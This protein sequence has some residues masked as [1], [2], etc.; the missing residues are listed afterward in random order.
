ML[1]TTRQS[2]D[3]PPPDLAHPITDSA[4]DRV[5]QTAEHDAESDANGTPDLDAEPIE[6]GHTDVASR[7]LG[8]DRHAEEVETAEAAGQTGIVGAA[9]SMQAFLRETGIQ[10]CIDSGKAFGRADNVAKASAHAAIA[11]LYAHLVDVYRV[12]ADRLMGS[13]H[14]KAL[15]TDKGLPCTEATR[16]NPY[17]TVIRL[18]SPGI[19]RKRAS[20][21]ATALRLAKLREVRPEELEAFMRANGG[22]DGCA[23]R[24][25]D[26]EKDAREGSDGSDSGQPPD[27]EPQRG[28]LFV[29]GADAL[30]P[31]RHVVAIVV[32]DDGAQIVDATPSIGGEAIH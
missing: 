21:L 13:P 16:G 8:G 15:C 6:A 28:G 12:N 23:K 14:L 18:S 31:G 17:M 25:R 30:S 32:G 19:G 24:F 29:R 10:Q 27:A 7:H 5:D 22:I 3:H 9:T 2:A 1:D 4:G 20:L 26:L 11:L